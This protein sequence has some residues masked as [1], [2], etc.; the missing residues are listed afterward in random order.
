MIL[1]ND[2]GCIMEGDFTDAEIEKFKK[3]NWKVIEK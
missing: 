2:Y 3:V 1:E